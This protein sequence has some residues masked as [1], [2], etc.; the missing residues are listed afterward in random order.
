MRLDRIPQDWPLPNDNYHQ[1][2]AEKIT[3]DLIK[4]DKSIKKV[5]DLGCGEGNS[6]K[7]FSEISNEIEWF[8]LDI[9]DSPEVKRR[10]TENERIFSFDGINIPFDSNSFDLVY[11]RQVFEHVQFPLELM[12]EVKRVLKDG[13]CLVGSTSHLEPYHS[14][15]HFNFTPYGFSFLCREA[16]LKVDLFR[17]GIDGITLIMRRLLN[18]PK[19]FNRWFIRESPLNKIINLA[20]KLKK[21]KVRDV[22]YI[23]LLFC[24][25]Y[26]FVVRKLLKDNLSK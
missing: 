16:G 3:S 2:T 23:K 18:Y 22:N 26:C 5:L 15:S 8:G 7:F 24:G 20:A 6:I 4:S 17:P 10:T 25:H 21:L 1:S 14:Y 19:F 12:K 11:C 13:G 9:E